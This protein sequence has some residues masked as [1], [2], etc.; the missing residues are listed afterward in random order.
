ML[1]TS[2]PRVDQISVSSAGD[3]VRLL[4]LELERSL[5]L[6]AVHRDEPQLRY[7]DGKLTGLRLILPLLRGKNCGCRLVGSKL[8][9]LPAIAPEAL[10]D[11]ALLLKNIQRQNF[12]ALHEGGKAGIMKEWLEGLIH[13]TGLALALIQPA[14]GL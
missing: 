7:L 13:A 2:K 8:V 5:A 6:A 9:F 12:M 3:A 11:L 14:L 4:W 1:A 10:K